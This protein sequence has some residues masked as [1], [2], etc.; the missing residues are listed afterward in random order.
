MG[1]GVGRARI[2]GAVLLVLAAGACAP[3]K[4]PPAGSTQKPVETR[5]TIGKTTQNVMPLA[6][7][8]QQG[9]QPAEMSITSGGLGAITSDA[10]RT[11]VGKMGVIAVEHQMQLVEAEH[12]PKPMNYDE[13]MTKIIGK[14]RPDG[15]QLPML[16]YYQEWAYDPDAKK[17]VVVEFPLRK[18]QRQQE[19]TG[20][21]GL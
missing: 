2:V 20:A 8:L 13:F 15:I 12:G 5:K 14:G 3:A 18:E 4:K 11:S 19:T 9:G 16:P 21:A 7:A 10:Y 6:E 1:A 17:L